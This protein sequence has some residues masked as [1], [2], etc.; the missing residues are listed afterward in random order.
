M[1]REEVIAAIE[2]L[3]GGNIHSQRIKDIEQQ[4]QAFSDQR[5]LVWQ[6]SWGRKALLIGIFGPMFVVISPLAKGSSMTLSVWWLP[7]LFGFT[8]LFSWVYMRSQPKVGGERFGLSK[9][10]VGCRYLLTGH[11][12]VLG[13]ETW[14][15][16]AV[17][18]ECGQAYPAVSK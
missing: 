4:L 17:C 13:N 16:P 12:S 2:K 7:L 18:P 8:I 11:E 9:K 3:R 14:V 5:M 10:C 15:G 6:G 1:R